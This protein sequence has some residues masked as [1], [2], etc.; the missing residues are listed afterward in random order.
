MRGHCSK[1]NRRCA[2][3]KASKRECCWTRF[4][5]SCGA[6]LRA[7]KMARPAIATSHSLPQTENENAHFNYA[8]LF[9]GSLRR[10][11]RQCERATVC[12]RSDAVLRKFSEG[13]CVSANCWDD[14][15]TDSAEIIACDLRRLQF[16]E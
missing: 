2:R 8:A 5:N 16:D 13:R 11:A 10:R 14:S 3:I 4:P 6:S 12:D 15:R 1:K 7:L 9:G